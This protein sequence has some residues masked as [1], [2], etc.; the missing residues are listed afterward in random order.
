MLQADL[1]PG[2]DWSS[3]S[4]HMSA[5]YL[6]SPRLAGASANVYEALASFDNELGR[7]DTALNYVE[8]ALESLQ[9]DAELLLIKAYFQIELGRIDDARLTLSRL[10]KAAEL[11]RLNQ[12]QLVRFRGFREAVQ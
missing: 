7:I 4:D 2:F 5:L 3:V 1:C 10:S 8:L 12:R 6:S 9:D 11:G